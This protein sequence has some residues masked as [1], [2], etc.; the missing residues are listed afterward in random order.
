MTGSSRLLRGR[1]RDA[2]RVGDMLRRLSPIGFVAALLALLLLI[3]AQSIA[4][5]PQ[6]YN[7]QNVGTSSNTFPFGQT[8]GKKVQWL[9][10]ANEISQPVPL[11]GGNAITKVYFFMTTAG[12]RTFT[13]FTIRLGQTSITTLPTGAWYDGTMQTVY[14]RASVNLTAGALAWMSIE[15]DTPF[16][17]DPTQSLVIEVN[18]CASTGSGMSVRQ[19]AITGTFRRSWSG[20]TTPCPFLWGGQG[21]EVANFG[22]DVMPLGTPGWTSQTSGI[23]TTLYSV[24]T[25]SPQIAWAAGAGGVVLRTTN[26]GTNWASVGGGNIGTMDLY[27]ITALDASTAMTTGTPTSPATTFL[28]RTTNGGTSWDTVYQQPGG[29]LNAIHMFNATNGI[30]QGDPLGGKWT[31]IRTTNGGASWERDT[32]NAPVQVGSEYGANNG[33]KVLGTTHI[34]WG[35]GTGNGLYRSTDGGTTWSRVALPASGFTA[36]VNFLNTSIGV[37][38]NSSG[39][40]SRTTDGGQTWTPVTIGTTGAIYSVGTAGTLDFW[41]T[42]GSTIQV[43]KNRGVSF[44]LD[45]TG[46][47]T[48]EHSDF[49]TLGANVFGWAVTS[50]GGIYA[51]FNPASIHD[52]GVQS[53]AKVFSTNRPGSNGIPADV[54]ATETAGDAPSL[55]DGSDLSGVGTIPNNFFASADTVGFRAVVKNFGTFNE[56]GYVLGWSV[57]G[58]AQPT[59]NRGAIA[60]GAFDTVTFQWNDAVN[61]MHTLRA[62]TVLAEEG[63]PA[64][65]TATLAFQVGR[66][67]GDTLYTFQVPGQIILGVSKMGP[68]DKLVFTSGGQSSATTADNKWIVTTMRGTILDTTHA[69]LN[70]TGTGGSPGFGFRDLAWD[71]RWLLT[72]DDNRIRRVDSASFTEIATPI[73]FGSATTSLHRGL[74]VEHANKIWKSNFTTEPVIAVDTTGATVRTLGTPAVAPYGIAFDKWTTKNRGWLWYSE[75]STTGGPVRLSKVDTATGAIVTTYNYASF[76][77]TGVSGGLEIIN[78]HPDYPGAVV[79]LLAAQRFPTSLLIAVYLGLDSTILSAD[80]QPSPVPATFSL[81]QNY[82]NPFNPSTII[83]YAL[84]TGGHVK[85]DVYNVLGQKIAELVD[86]VRPAG[87]HDAVWNGRNRA[88]A[89]V[90]AGVYLYR[91]EVQAG[92]GDPP[93]ISTRKMMLIK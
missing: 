64:N 5:T 33:M 78:D 26:G 67:P 58:V 91:I 84:P 59:I 93:F 57:N 85:L 13:D 72:S 19:N 44:A 31:V 2:V 62:W 77:T 42:R 1:R 50:T 34:W 4:Q 24:K 28:F 55:E 10:L 52:L 30:A 89:E 22:V 68:S 39:V 23:T 12:T 53:L 40:A 65:D 80:E 70:P 37:V 51:Y 6:Y 15:L 76:T 27:N 41:A 46:T 35:P 56:T 49:I 18:Q 32:A 79:A 47:G 8:A 14:T 38:G 9:V 48:F 83:R 11:P 71:G 92:N 45:F 17:Y 73:T 36:G 90:A 61:G 69:Q 21:P 82:P 54:S 75:P 20:T 3:G 25:V 88:G 43:S 63:N 29:F 74:A 60:A 81:G 16:P 66:V 87:V 86:G 7:Y